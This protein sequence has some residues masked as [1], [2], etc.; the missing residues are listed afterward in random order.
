MNDDILKK[1]QNV[2]LDILNNVIDICDRNDLT[3]FLMDGSMLGCVRHGGFIPWDD[4]VDIGLP[5]P[6]YDKFVMI[7]SIELPEYLILKNY[8]NDNDYDR[9][10]TRVVNNNVKLYHN[11]YVSDEHMEPAWIDIFPIDGIPN[12]KL[13][14]ELHKLWFLIVRLYYHFSCFDRTVNLTRK[15]RTKLQMFLIWVGKTFKIGRK[16]D[17]RKILMYLEKILKKYDYVNSKYIVN[18]YSSY[19]FKETY[20]KKWFDNGTFLQFCNCQMRVPKDYDKVLTHLYGEYLIPPSDD[21]KNKHDIIK[22]VF[23]ENENV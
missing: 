1:L 21:R 17:T 10:N 2:E 22:I 14:F 11:S 18:A 15:D 8:Q 7:A 12:N 13:I 6:D 16:G 5:R 20:D 9:L 19:M 3:Y 23:L 4:D